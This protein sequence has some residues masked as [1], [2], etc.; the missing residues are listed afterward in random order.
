[1]SR[2]SANVAGVLAA[3]ATALLLYI[4]ID[5]AAEQRHVPELA[6]VVM[7]IFAI[8]FGT[9][10]FTRRTVDR[11]VAEYEQK[12]PAIDEVRIAKL[13]AED[14][15]SEIRTALDQAFRSGLVAGAERASRINGGNSGGYPKL[16]HVRPGE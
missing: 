3:I 6:R 1:M 10:F 15:K 8:V 9:C 5:K 11:V 4:E 2:T 13:V 16:A 7:L 14:M 12:R